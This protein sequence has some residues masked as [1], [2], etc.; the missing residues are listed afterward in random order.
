[1]Q[2]N[3]QHWSSCAR[4]VTEA[5]VSTQA[6]CLKMLSEHTINFVPLLAAHEFE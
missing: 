1:M 5:T 3:A 4:R 6:Q 2:A